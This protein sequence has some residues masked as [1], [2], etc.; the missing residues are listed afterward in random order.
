[1]NDKKWT[2]T[3]KVITVE[4][5]ERTTTKKKTTKGLRSKRFTQYQEQV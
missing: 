5:C 3:E 4:I 1:M 2:K